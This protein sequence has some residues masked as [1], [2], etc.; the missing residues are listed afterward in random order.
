M[1]DILKNLKIHIMTEWHVLGVIF[2]CSS[3]VT[4]VHQELSGDTYVACTQ[5]DT[6]C[7]YTLEYTSV[8]AM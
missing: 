5:I 2:C 4:Y 3:F 7:M 6:L 1:Y 8:T